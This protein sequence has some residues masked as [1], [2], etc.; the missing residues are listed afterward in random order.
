MKACQTTSRGASKVR[1]QTSSAS[2]E[3]TV[4]VSFLNGSVIVTMIGTP[5]FCLTRRVAPT[6]RR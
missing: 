5:Y 6:S 3:Y 4:V 2:S 1:S